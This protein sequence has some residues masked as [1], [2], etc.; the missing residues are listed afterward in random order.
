VTDGI[1]SCSE[2]PISIDNNTSVSSFCYYDGY[3]YY[4]VCES[5]SSDY[6]SWLYRCDANFS[7]PELLDEMRWG[8]SANF[9]QRYF[10]IDNGILYYLAKGGETVNAIKLDTLTKITAP[11]PVF[12]VNCNATTYTSANEDVQIRIYNDTILFTDAN[13]DLYKFENGEGIKLA[14]DA[15]LDGG[16][17]KEYIYYAQFGVNG[18]T[19]NC[20]LCRMPVSGG[21]Y[22]VLS[23]RM[24]AGGGGPFFCY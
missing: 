8:D 12:S 11:V 13:H 16:C 17:T 19:S 24:P 2:L 22:E 21:N 6:N 15:Y 4:I 20:N 7:T 9:P 18:N 10:L 14:S 3:V 1:P 23:S 5:G